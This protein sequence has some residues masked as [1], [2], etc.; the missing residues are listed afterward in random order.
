MK[1]LADISNDVFNK[2]LNGA[3]FIEYIN[4]DD[5]DIM[6]LTSVDGRTLVAKVTPVV[7]INGHR[8][9]GIEPC[10]KLENVQETKKTCDGECKGCNPKIC[11][12]IE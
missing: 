1:I 7:H 9:G 5:T 8:I 11:P 6:E 3:N 2:I 12:G 10:W 4:F